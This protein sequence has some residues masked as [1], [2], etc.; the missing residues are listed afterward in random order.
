MEWVR[1]TLP[2][3][4]PEGDEA[5]TK[6]LKELAA[7]LVGTAERPLPDVPPDV[8]KEVLRAIDDPDQRRRFLLSA[9]ASHDSLEVAR[10]P[11]GGSASDRS[12][13]GWALAGALAA[14]LGIAGSSGGFAP[15]L[16]AALAVALGARA[17]W[18]LRLCRRY[19]RH[20]VAAGKQWQ[21]VLRERS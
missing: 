3:P 10:M 1:A 11:P 15:E 18:R 13:R 21:D 20:A 17:A 8:G 9:Q 5:V 16:V 2:A 6:I 12:S 19:W 7:E 14:F 4:K